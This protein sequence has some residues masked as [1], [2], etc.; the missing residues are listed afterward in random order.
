MPDMPLLPE[1]PFR[2]SCGDHPTRAQVDG[3]GGAGVPAQ[4]PGRYG[5]DEEDEEEDNDYDD[6]D[7]EEGEIVGDDGV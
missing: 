3:S 5:G 1:L 4:Y 2:N 7:G 6:D